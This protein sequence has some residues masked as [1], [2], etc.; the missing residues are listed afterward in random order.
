PRPIVVLACVSLLNDLASEM[1]VPLIPLLLA[2]VLA[3]GPIALGVI[4]GAADAVSN[5]LKLW[6]GRR[7]DRPGRRRKPYIVIGYAMSNVVRPLIALSGS[8]FTVLVIRVTD[9]IGKGLRTAPRDAL[10]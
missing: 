8:W 5:L 6:A 2:T 3:A 1:V 4:E 10:I 7:S 9:R